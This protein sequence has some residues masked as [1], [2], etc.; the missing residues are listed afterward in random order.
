M[1]SELAGLAGMRDRPCLKEGI[2]Y[3]AYSGVR[4]RWGIKMKN[5]GEECILHDLG[6]DVV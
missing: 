3:V 1:A 5:Q 6:K 2:I 4:L